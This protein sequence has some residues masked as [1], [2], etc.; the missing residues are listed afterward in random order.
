VR[1]PWAAVVMLVAAPAAAQL[2][3]ESPP[4]DYQTAPVH[5]PVARL[6]QR[7]DAGEVELDYDPR[8]GYLPDVL[9]LLDVPVSTQGLVFSQTSFQLRKISPRRP[10]AIYFNDDTYVGWVQGGDVIEIASVDPRQGAIF[11]TLDQDRVTH[12]RFLRD[13]GQCV[14]CHASSRTQ[15]VPGL[16]VRSVYADADGRPQLGSGTFTTDHR[17]PFRQR[18]GG[19]YV[20]GT[21]GA[22]RHMGNVISPDRDNPEEIDVQ[23]GAN[24]TDL[25]ELVDTTPYLA[26]TSDIVAL[27]IL[28]HQTQMHNYITLAN[29]ETRH[30]QHYDQ[31]M[32]KALGRPEDHQSDSTARR[33]AVAAEKLVRYMLFVDEFPLSSPVKGVSGFAAEFSAGGPR[34]GHDRSLRELDLNGRLLKYPCSYLIYSDAFDGLPPAVKQVVY[35]RLLEV[36][37]GTEQGGDFAHLSPADRSAILEILRETKPDFPTLHIEEMDK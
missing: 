1:T 19:W 16:L 33:I 31:I 11:Y 34:D 6:Q 21:H 4:I 30:A 17:S 29:F 25:A 8:H 15:G 5:D 9:R 20:S 27:M 37:T 24:R 12:P 28:E 7:I 18:W 35:R 36:L 14:T 10:R 13:R 22:L 23:R 32:N 3:F 2:Q 26:S